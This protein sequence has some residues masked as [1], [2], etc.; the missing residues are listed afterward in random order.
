MI[1]EDEVL[2]EGMEAVSDT[3]DVNI[4]HLFPD[5]SQQSSQEEKSSNSQILGVA[6]DKAEPVNLYMSRQNNKW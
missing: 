1:N 2:L 5:E 4:E 3:T 6:A